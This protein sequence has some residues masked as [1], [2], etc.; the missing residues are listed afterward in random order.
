M[1]YWWKYP[2]INLISSSRSVTFFLL[3][4]IGF[5]QTLRETDQKVKKTKHLR[6]F[7]GKLE[8]LCS[9]DVTNSNA[10][11]VRQDIKS[12]GVEPGAREPVT[13]ELERHAI[14]IPEGWLA[15]NS[16]TP[17]PEMSNFVNFLENEDIPIF[18]LDLLV[19]K[20]WAKQNTAVG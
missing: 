2:S 14:D 18:M 8:K 10:K 12:A 16:G 7:H 19:S 11:R 20:C 6:S 1:K 15:L 9:P 13:G 17:I 4:K 3:V 5:L